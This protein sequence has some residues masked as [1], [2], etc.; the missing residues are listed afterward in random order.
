MLLPSGLTVSIMT[1]MVGSIVRA[2][3]TSVTLVIFPTNVCERERNRQKERAMRSKL[4]LLG[5]TNQSPRLRLSEQDKS[6]GLE[7]TSQNTKR[8][9]GSNYVFPLRWFPARRG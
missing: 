6:R 1:V 3:N 7:M 8:R 2:Q 5:R 4:K 9:D